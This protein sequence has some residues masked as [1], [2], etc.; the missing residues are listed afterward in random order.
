MYVG[1]TLLPGNARAYL[2]HT[3]HMEAEIY[4]RRALPRLLALPGPLPVP[5]PVLV[6]V[7]VL[8][9]PQSLV[10]TVFMYEALLRLALH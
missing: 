8:V 7:L 5:V 6:L 2:H 1:T 4:M 9:L 3:S 10:R